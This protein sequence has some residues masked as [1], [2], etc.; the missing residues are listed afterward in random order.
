MSPYRYL[1]LLSS[2]IIAY[3]IF[4][5]VPSTSTIYGALIIVPSTFFIIYSEKKEFNKQTNE[6]GEKE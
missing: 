1:E 3:I 5:E 4:G 2:A 6:H